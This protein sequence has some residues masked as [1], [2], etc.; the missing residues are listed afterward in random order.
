MANWLRS[1]IWVESDEPARARDSSFNRVWTPPGRDYESLRVFAS[2]LA[3]VM[4]TTSRVEADYFSFINYRKNE[5]NAGLSD[6][7][8]EGVLFSRQ[9][10]EL[11]RYFNLLPDQ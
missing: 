6:F 11:E 9:A 7:S 8:L 4:P 3:T 10:K 5:Y 2:G 1:Q